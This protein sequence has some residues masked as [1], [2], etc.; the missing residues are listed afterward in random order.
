MVIPLD[1]PGPPICSNLGL[2][3]RLHPSQYLCVLGPGTDSD[4]ETDMGN[5]L[6]DCLVQAH[7][8]LWKNKFALLAAA[9]IN[10]K[11]SIIV[12]DPLKFW[13]DPD[14]TFFLK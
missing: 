9:Q 12:P 2:E 14:P 8:I 7:L 4:E 5:N 3:L 6:L 10:A 11:V 13:Y 1:R